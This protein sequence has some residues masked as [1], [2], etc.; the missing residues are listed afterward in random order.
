MLFLGW[1]Q[2]V[3]TSSRSSFDL[4]KDAS[5][6]RGHVR[7]LLQEEQESANLRMKRKN[8]L[9]KEKRMDKGKLPKDLPFKSKKQEKLSM[10]ETSETS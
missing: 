4:A 10:A 5:W 1:E 3:G 2:G 7:Q 9:G 8:I 6:K